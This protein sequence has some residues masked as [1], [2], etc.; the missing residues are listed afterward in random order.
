RLRQFKLWSTRVI[1]PVTFSDELRRQWIS[2]DLAV[3]TAF[4]VLVDGAWFCGLESIDNEDLRAWLTRHGAHET[5]VW[6]GIVRGLYDLVFAYEQGMTGD[7]TPDSPGKPNLAA[8]VA[9]EIL[10]RIIFTYSGSVSYD[11]QAGMGEVVFAPIY[12]ALR[13]KGVNFEFFHRV[14]HLEL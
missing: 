14:K 11:L 5:T 10:R 9:L 8:G 4:G 6:S 12:K 13:N 2:I 3:T 7:G 1:D